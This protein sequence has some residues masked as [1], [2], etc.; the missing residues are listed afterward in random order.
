MRDIDEKGMLQVMKEALAIINDDTSGFHLSFDIDAIDP[1]YAPGVS[2]PVTGGL[3]LRESHLLL[4]MIYDSGKL[5]SMEF[6]EL[7]PFT[8]NGSQTAN[9]VVDLILSALGKSIV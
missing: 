1:I 9:L 6:V 8:D 5:N 4:E 2:T 3:S 7:N